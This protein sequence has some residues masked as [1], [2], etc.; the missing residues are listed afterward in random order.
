MIAAINFLAV[1]EPRPLAFWRRNP[2]G[3]LG[4][5]L[6]HVCSLFLG[7]GVSQ[8]CPCESLGWGENQLQG[9]SHKDKFNIFYLHRGLL[10]M[11]GS[12]TQI[13]GHALSLVTLTALAS[14]VASFTQIIFRVFSKVYFFI[15]DYSTHR[16]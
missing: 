16:Y 10:L 1:S 9:S 2:G 12:I 6:C 5:G 15:I 4:S 11:R 3:C 7:I 14:V 13:S 8:V